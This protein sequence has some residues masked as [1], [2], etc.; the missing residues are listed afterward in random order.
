VTL[1]LGMSKAEGVFLS[2]DYRVTNLRTGSVMDDATVKFLAVHYPPEGGP[3]ALIAYTGVAYLADGT[4]VG[5]WIR[6]TLRGESEVFDLSM[7]HLRN[8]LDRDVSPM[9]V[10]LIVN[11]IALHG[12]RRYFGGMSNVRRSNWT[13]MD[14]F[15]YVMEELP[16]PR[17]FANGSGAETVVAGGH[18]DLLSSQLPVRPRRIHDHL[19]LLAT[20]NRRVA[21]VNS[22]VSPHCHVA[23]INADDRYGPE[24]HVFA[25]GQPVPMTMPILLFGIDLTFMMEHA[26]L[27]VDGG[28]EAPD[29]DEMNRHLQRRP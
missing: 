26:R 15:G 8:R 23:F 14:S 20:I 22:S 3:K 28:A 13:V 27:R 21:E 12:D 1:I 24:S 6:E 19:N 7:A 5:D 16:E 25:H 18:F 2:V 10:P 29:T 11:A 9:R 17:G 4:P